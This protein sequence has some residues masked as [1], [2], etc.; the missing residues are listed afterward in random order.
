M[1]ASA[2]RWR[3]FV[4]PAIVGI[5]VLVFVV[6][7]VIHGPYPQDP[8][9]HDFADDLTYWGVPNAANVLSNL[10]F[11][12]PA[13]YGFARS[14]RWLGRPWE[15]VGTF[16]FFAGLLAVAAGSSYYHYQPA[17]G[18]LVWDRLPITVVFMALFALVLGDTIH[19]KAGEWLLAPLIALGCFS[20]VIWLPKN[21]LR[22]YGVV[23]FGSM[24][25][26]M[27]LSVFLARRLDRVWLVGAGVLYGFAKFLEKKDDWVFEALRPLSG[28]ALKHF[29][30]AFATLFIAI[31]LTS[32][33]RANAP[34][35]GSAAPGS[36]S[37]R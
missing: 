13:T 12:V 24:L 31:M 15:K 19:D 14:D 20:A 34:A 23:Q 28:H 35:P 25:A 17:N 29:F 11:V 30:A 5:V 32:R 3:V 1:F 9:Y 7:A 8:K 4:G 26:M 2:R 18:P 36:P 16:L 6:G 22:I 37:P 10:F 33:P 27:I 21:D